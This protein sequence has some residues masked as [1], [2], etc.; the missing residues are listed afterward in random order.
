VTHEA[1]PGVPGDAVMFTSDAYGAATTADVSAITA[2]WLEA[3]AI[4]PFIQ[5]TAVKTLEA[6]ALQP[7]ERVLDVGCG[8]GVFLG[9][10]ASAVGSA[11]AVTGLDH[12]SAFLAEARARLVAGGLSDVVS[13]YQ[14][15]A[16]RLPFPD[17]SFDAAHAERVLMHLE[18][19]DQAI[20][21]LL[22][23]VRPEGRVVAAEVHPMGAT[24][25]A[26]DH[27]LQAVIERELVEGFR[28]PWMGLELRRRFAMAGLED[29]RVAA[30]ID[31]EHELDP[32][33]GEEMRR[34]SEGLADAGT[35]DRERARRF[36]ERLFEANERGFHCGY[37]LMFIA[38]GRVPG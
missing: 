30:V 15:D 6:L 38:V 9:A 23:V 29:V 2:D 12:S 19:P 32:V 8:T 17:R 21:E 16:H 3:Q 13:L 24:M 1:R 10:L 34:I 37:A 18:D 5:A 27:E 20:R 28:H 25:D 33:E 4:H 7:G 31:V 35:V 36:M 22:R 11:G 26:T 14:G